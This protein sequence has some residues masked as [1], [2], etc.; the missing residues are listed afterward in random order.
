MQYLEIVGRVA[1]AGLFFLA[2]VVLPVWFTYLD[3]RNHRKVS[4]ELAGRICQHR[5]T[6]EKYF[7][8]EVDHNFNVIARRTDNKI[9][10]FATNELVCVS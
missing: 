2:L 1:L 5:L 4:Q 3:A 7:V 9:E 8:I 6:G 10:S